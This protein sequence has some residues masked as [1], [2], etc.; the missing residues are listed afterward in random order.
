VKREWL[1]WVW[2]GLALS[3][4]VVG[5]LLIMAGLVMIGI[6]GSQDLW[7]WGEAR[8]MGYL[9]FFIGIILSVLGVL[10]MRIMRNRGVV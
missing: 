7:G 8:G 1:S 4:Y 6:L 2:A 9:A 3:L 10:I 5:G